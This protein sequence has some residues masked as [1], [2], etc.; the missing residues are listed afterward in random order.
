[1]LSQVM[2]IWQSIIGRAKSNILF[3][4]FIFLL[5]GNPSWCVVECTDFVPSEAC[6]LGLLYRYL[7][8]EKSQDLRIN[9]LVFVGSTCYGQYCALFLP[10]NKFCGV[11]SINSICLLPHCQEL[12]LLLIKVVTNDKM[13]GGWV[14]R[15][16]CSLERSP[17]IESW[18]GE[19]WD[20]DRS[21]NCKCCMAGKT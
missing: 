20:W 19:A 21:R 3:N 10:K 17:S 8:D 2:S 7:V 1:M 6:A 12:C 14:A 11:V 5:V 16:V 13:S 9:G 18:E 15:S 4:L